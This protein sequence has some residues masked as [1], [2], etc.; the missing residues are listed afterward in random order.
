MQKCKTPKTLISNI[1][2]QRLHS[3]PHLTSPRAAASLFPAPSRL[4]LRRDGAAAACLFCAPSRLW[5]RRPFLPAAWRLG[6]FLVVPLPVVPRRGRVFGLLFCKGLESFNSQFDPHYKEH[7]TEGLRTMV[8]LNQD[9]KSGVECIGWLCS[10]SEP[11][12]DMLIS[13]KLL[14]IQ[15]TK[16]TGYVDL[17]EKFNLKIIRAIDIDK[18]ASFLDV[19]NLLKCD[20]ECTTTIEELISNIGADIQEC[21]E[22]INL[23]KKGYKR[24]RRMKKDSKR[25][26]CS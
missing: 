7:L 15:R 4:W 20:N 9:N 16:M 23:Q 24:R 14:I 5:L 19:C 12:I 3:Q 17:E 25:L 21:G 8:G 18:S 11:E 10:L 1:P 6:S 26:R 13:L 22:T 2:A